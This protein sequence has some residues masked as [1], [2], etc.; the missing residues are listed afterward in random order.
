LVLIDPASGRETWAG[1]AL[2][3]PL[4]ELVVGDVNGD[5]LAEVV[6]LEGNYA[7]QLDGTA[8]RIDIWR[9]RGFGFELL[10]RSEPDALRELRLLPAPR[11]GILAIAVR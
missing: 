9:W 1:S 4:F 11:G 5:G 7:S 6:A 2:P 10:W 8:N 3:V